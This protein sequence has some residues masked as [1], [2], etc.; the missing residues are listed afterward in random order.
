MPPTHIT[1]LK[2]IIWILPIFGYDDDDDDF[3]YLYR[4][5]WLSRT[6]RSTSYRVSNPYAHLDEESYQEIIEIGAN[7]P[8]KVTG[9]SSVTPTE[10]PPPSWYPSPQRLWA[11]GA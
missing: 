10:N 3:R 1:P 4:D 5:F 6:A 2:G 9:Q 11:L 8:M 7:Q